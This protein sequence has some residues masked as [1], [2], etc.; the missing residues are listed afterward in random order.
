[1]TYT[2]FRIESISETGVYEIVQ[3]IHSAERRY[4]RTI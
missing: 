4:E 1:M 3:T 2:T